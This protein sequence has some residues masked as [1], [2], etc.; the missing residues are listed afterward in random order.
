TCGSKK[1]E[2]TKV[3]Y[4]VRFAISNNF[5][6]T[7]QVGNCYYLRTRIEHSDMNNSNGTY[8]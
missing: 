7:Y 6:E 3:R 2:V 4:F 8:Q 5:N 1:M